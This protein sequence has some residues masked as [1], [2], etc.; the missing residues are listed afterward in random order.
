[1]TRRFHSW[2]TAASACVALLAG[3]LLSTTA[4]AIDKI[5]LKDGTVVEGQIK[6][7]L[8]GY[9]WFLTRTGGVEREVIYKPGDVERVERDAEGPATAAGADRAMASDSRRPAP[10]GDRAR[11]SSGAPRAAVLTLGEGGDKDM[12]G[13]FMTAEA[14]RRL[15]PL[16][17]EE[18]VEILVLRINSGG[19][20][21]LEIERLSDLIEYELKP[22]FRVVGW[23][24]S[25]ISAAAMTAHA[26]EEIYFMTRGNYGACTGWFGQLQA[27]EGR[28]LEEVLYLMERISA[29]GGYDTRIM[30]SMQV[31]EPLSATIDD[32]GNVTWYQSLEG[33]ITVNPEGR[34]LTF[35]AQDAERLKFS[36]GTADTLAQLERAMGLPE[37]E[38]VGEYVPGVSYPVCKAEKANRAWRDKVFEDQKR[39]QEY[40]G[41]YQ[42]LI[43][44][45]RQTPKE[46]RGRFVNQARRAF[47]VIKR[48]VENN[49]NFQLF[50]FNMTPSEWEEWVRE[51][52]QLLRDLMR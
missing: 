33:D 52:E 7:E 6:Q 11:S 32:N 26:I 24:Q 10:A 25:A 28:D 41:S 45:A 47:N 30:R 5:H 51:Q 36:K 2:L 1:M 12:V 18:K 35:N 49:P 40:R 37:V 23:I 31:E 4:S 16:L 43:A 13:L 15:I 42:Q 29:R 17:E 27:V 22:K 39:T 46:E 50:T 9:I 19:G 8:D 3:A 21:L 38:W 14:V 44:M 34:I 48:M 20:A